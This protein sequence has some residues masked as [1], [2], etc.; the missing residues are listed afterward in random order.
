MPPLSLYNEIGQLTATLKLCDSY[1]IL[2]STQQNLVNWFHRFIF[3]KTLKFNVGGFTKNGCRVVLLNDNDTGVTSSTQNVGINFKEMEVLK[4]NV[5][6]HDGKF[7][8]DIDLSDSVVVEGH[9][10]TSEQDPGH[11]LVITTNTKSE[12]K[13]I[14][15]TRKIDYRRSNSVIRSKSR[16]IHRNPQSLDYRS[17]PMSLTLRALFLPVILYRVDSLVSMH[18]LRQSVPNED[19]FLYAITS[20]S[21]AKK[22]RFSS[23]QA[24]TPETPSTLLEYFSPLYSSKIVPLFKLLEAVTCKSSVDDFNLER[25][26]TLGDSFLK[27]AVS[28]HVYWHESHKNEGKLTKYR[29]QKISNKNLYKLA[30][31][32]DLAGYIKYSIFDKGTWLP[33]GF[34]PPRVRIGNLPHLIDDETDDVV[35][36][37][38]D[39]VI[40][41]TI[42]DKGVADSM[43][44]LMGAYFLHCGYLGALR[45]MTWLGVFDEGNRRKSPTPH[46]PSKYANYPLPTIEIPPDEEKTRYEDILVRQTKEMAS[47]EKKIKYTFKNKVS[48]I[49]LYSLSFQL[50]SQVKAWIVS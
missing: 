10:K 49:L 39:D 48:I 29:K 8:T 25:L 17:S 38:V 23:S 31:K 3:T 26:E 34:S 18:E 21:P 13:A 36:V 24:S 22:A 44:A 37:C 28:I 19:S 30:K 12:V 9:L 2:T 5:S 14:H 40:T 42:P 7:S 4:R 1:D 35:D 11:Y 50:S 33:P 46:Y 32:R 20:E 43:E 15:H 47:F 16:I 45:F 6:K 41:Q 27:M